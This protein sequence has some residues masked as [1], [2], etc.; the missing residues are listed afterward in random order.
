MNRFTIL[1]GDN[2]SEHRV[3]KDAGFAS[4]RAEEQVEC[5]LDVLIGIGLTADH[6]TRFF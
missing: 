4:I 5:R 1:V 3:W 6:C 2:L